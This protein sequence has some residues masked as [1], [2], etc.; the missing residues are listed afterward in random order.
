MPISCQ[1]T[2]RAIPWLLDDE[3][4][5]TQLLELEAH[6]N[7][8]DA[9]RAELEREAVLRASVRRALEVQ[10]APLALRRSIRELL[11]REYRRRQLPWVQLWPAAAAAV[12]LLAFIWKGSTGGAL[13]ELDE[14]AQRHA[15]NLPLDIKTSDADVTKVQR[16]FDGKLPFAVNVPRIV[17]RPVRLLGGRITHLRN[18]QAA[19]VRYDVPRG[20]V[21][22]FVYQ[23]PGFD[24]SEVAPGYG[25]YRM[26]IHH[27][28]G[29]TVAR[30]RLGGLVY[31]IVSDL[32]ANEILNM[33]EIGS[34]VRR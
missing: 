10:I 17:N 26:D 29:Y 13:Y 28:R 21:A 18:R 12:I 23:D 30:Y 3:I 5:P 25:Q 24:M 32:P 2:Q 19:Y 14:A 22:V 6:M 1:D 11:D 33:L 9:C 7:E 4:E 27:M 16:Y 34:R 31:S 20:R 8:C 15:S